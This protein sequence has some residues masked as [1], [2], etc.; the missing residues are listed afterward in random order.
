MLIL[1]TVAPTLTATLDGN[2]VADGDVI[3]VDLRDG[4]V[5]LEYSVFDLNHP[6]L[7]KSYSTTSDARVTYDYYGFNLNSASVGSEVVFWAQ[8]IDG[9]W[10]ASDPIQVTVRVV[11]KVKKV[12]DKKDKPHK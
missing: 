8:A 5:R 7:L 4:P 2:P 1:D 10:N 12:K 9:E 6:E 11:K 3:E